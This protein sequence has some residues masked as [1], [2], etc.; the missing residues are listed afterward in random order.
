MSNDPRWGN[1]G[2]RGDNQGPPDLEEIWQDFNQRLSRLFGKRG[3]GGNDPSGR[4]SEGSPFRHLG[5]GLFALATIILMLWL[6]SGIYTV[7]TNER[8]V[9]LRLGRYVA[10]VG[11][12]LNW[13]WPAPI[14]THEIVD[15]TGL[16]TVTVGNR[17]GARTPMLTADLNIVNVQFAVQYVLDN[18][19]DHLFNNRE[20]NEEFVRQIAETAMREIVGLSM[21]NTVL[22]EGRE[23]LANDA[24]Q[25]IQEILDRYAAG[26]HVS[27]VTMEEIQPPEQV[28]DAFNDATKASQDMVRQKS[29]GEAYANDIIPRAEGTASRM[30]EEAEAY[31]ARVIASAEG[32]AARFEQVLTEF[33]RA[34]E[35]TRERLYLETMQYVFSRT[36]KL[37]I[38][39]K[40]GG[41][42][43]FLPL[44]KIMQQGAAPTTAREKTTLEIPLVPAQAAAP[45]A[46]TN[47]RDNMRNRDR[48]ER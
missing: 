8:A 45:L 33:K 23:Q 47:P 41:N 34:P 28:Q 27:R 5:S 40:G 32:E 43:L 37:M 12:G 22:Y 20:P 46:Q 14:E 17:G 10:T 19:K 48:G 6:G 36:S 26:I 30:R 35:V 15:L 42:L 25:L 21:M 3:G 1:R 16:R 7:N 39:A 9:V 31:R 11:P 44:D 13:R 4:G 18:P 24:Q 29:E 38:D 2:N